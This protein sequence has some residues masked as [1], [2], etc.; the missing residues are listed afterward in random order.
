MPTLP[1][2][3]PLPPGTT[4]HHLMTQ[5][6][7]ESSA[8]MPSSGAGIVHAITSGTTRSSTAP[9]AL[10]TWRRPSASCGPM[11]AHTGA[12]GKIAP[13]P[14]L[15]E[16]LTQ[17]GLLAC[18]T[19]RLPRNIQNFPRYYAPCCGGWSRSTASDSSASRRS[20]C[21]SRTPQEVWHDRVT[22]CTS[23]APTSTP[24]TTWA[25][26]GPGATL[27]P[28]WERPRARLLEVGARGRHWVAAR[29][30]LVRRQA[31]RAP[32]QKTGRGQPPLPDL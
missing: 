18:W 26:P 28:A 5:G 16:D 13:S 24:S 7:P 15:V 20:W 27:D 19:R 25:L 10:P 9:E 22:C 6:M 1:V 23:I 14:D 17:D 8:Y 4:A 32:A 31:T 12:V 3:V 2:R 30:H 21:R 11:S 29:P